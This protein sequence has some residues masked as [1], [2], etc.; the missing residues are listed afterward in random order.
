MGL[1]FFIKGIMTGF[2]LAVPIGPIG[3][4]C[5]R[6]TLIEGRIRGLIIG[7]GGATADLLFSGIAAFGVTT[8]S[9]VID[10]HRVWIRLAG[11]TFL[12][13]MGVIT[14]LTQPKQRKSFIR[15]REMLKSYFLTIMLAFTN[16]LTI[17]AFIAVFATLGIGHK[18]DHFYISSL[19]AGVFIGSCLWFLLLSAVANRYGE[20]FSRKGLPWINKVT[21]VLIVV[22]GMVAIASVL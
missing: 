18:V 11:G 8:I 21:G 13:G 4:M 7:L 19:V 17:F 10:N 16:P 6:K 14:Y 3:I 22:S 2:A 5:V 1:I 9:T 12:L 15:S 20:K